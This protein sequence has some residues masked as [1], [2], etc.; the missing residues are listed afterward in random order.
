MPTS[1]MYALIDPRENAILHRNTTYK[2]NG[3]L[4]RAKQEQPVLNL[5]RVNSPAAKH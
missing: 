5:A 3:L 2:E 1:T 4:S